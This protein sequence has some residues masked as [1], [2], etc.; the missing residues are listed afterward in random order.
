MLSSVFLIVGGGISQYS[1]LSQNSRLNKLKSSE[2]LSQ[3][4]LSHNEINSPL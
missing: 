4:T 3:Y 2:K 1:Y